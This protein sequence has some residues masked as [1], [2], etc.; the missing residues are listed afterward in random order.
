MRGAPEQ[1]PVRVEYATTAEIDAE[2]DSPLGRIFRH[3]CRQA[4]FSYWA[5]VRCE[6]HEVAAKTTRRCEHCR[7]HE[8]QILALKLFREKHPSFNYRIPEEF[9]RHAPGKR[10]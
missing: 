2:R 10:R 4:R 1:I 6:V 3:P 9:R 8:S 7:A 5:M